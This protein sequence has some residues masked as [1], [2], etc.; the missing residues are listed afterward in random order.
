[1]SITLYDY[2]RSSAAYRLRITLNHMGLDYDAIPVDL[3]TGANRGAENLARN[4]QGLVPTLVIDDHTFT[5]SLAIIEYLNETRHGDLLPATALGRARV[6]AISYAIAM[7]IHAV[8]NLSVAKFATDNSGGGITMKDWM[9]MFIAKGLAA[10]ERMLDAPQT[11][12]FCHG[13]RMSIADICLVPQIFN[14]QRWEVDT[15]A[16]PRINR[17][18]A[19]LES[20]KAVADAHPDMH[21]PA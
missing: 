10:V 14:A 11:G 18:I 20:I 1:M 19:V 6:R 7:E 2:W 8:C 9:Q 4:P 13:D 17:I 5:Q 15:S 16:M 12:R 3:L 21:Q